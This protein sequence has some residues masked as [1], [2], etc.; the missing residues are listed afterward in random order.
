MY[1][2]NVRL[3]SKADMCSAQVDVRFTPKRTCA[4]QLAHVCFVPIATDAPQQSA[5]L[6]DHRVG[7]GEYRRR[8]GEAEYLGG[9]EIDHQLV[10]GR[11]LHRQVGR[12]LAL[13][14]TI[15]VGGSAARVVGKI[16]SIGD[17]ATG[18]DKGAYEE[19]RGQLVSG[20]SG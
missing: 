11:C 14:N 5:S 1:V 20:R 9:L 17:Q 12:F 2:R 19:D 4:V 13:E 18:S 7:A 6:F 3:G 10:L 16:G 15:D 8:N